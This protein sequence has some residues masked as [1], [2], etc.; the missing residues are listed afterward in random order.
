MLADDLTNEQRKWIL[1]QYWK[2]ENVE[3]VR[4][5]WAK[6]F[7][8]SPRSRLTIYRI[9]DKFDETGSICNAPKSGRPVSVTS[10][11]NELLVS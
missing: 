2:I 8:T 4:Q 11:E 9:S 5:K 10:Q 7:D 1:K 6:E 3:K